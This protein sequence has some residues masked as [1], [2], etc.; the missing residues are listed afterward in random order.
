MHRLKHV[1]Y[2][3]GIKSLNK[4]CYKR[5]RKVRYVHICCYFGTFRK[6]IGYIVKARFN[7]GRIFY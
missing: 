7:D 6:N 2:P 4:R 3:S 5:L 1:R